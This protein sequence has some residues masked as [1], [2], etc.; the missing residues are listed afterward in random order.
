MNA[1]IL[2]HFYDVARE[3]WVF[4][5][6]LMA[7]GSGMLL[8]MKGKQTVPVMIYRAALS[9]EFKTTII[10]QISKCDF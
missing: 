10:E 7:I 8:K 9:P 6:A 4:R 3:G 5:G 2:A 1:H